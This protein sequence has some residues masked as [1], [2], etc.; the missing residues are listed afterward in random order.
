VKERKFW[1]RQG[2][3]RNYGNCSKYGYIVWCEM[4]GR[5]YGVYIE[6]K[7]KIKNLSDCL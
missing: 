1:R 3:G 4:K 6:Q 7:N 2:E 5:E